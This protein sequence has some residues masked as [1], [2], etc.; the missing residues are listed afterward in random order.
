M[1]IVFKTTG[2]RR[3]I[4]APVLDWTIAEFVRAWRG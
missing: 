2:R 4:P 1:T 3:V